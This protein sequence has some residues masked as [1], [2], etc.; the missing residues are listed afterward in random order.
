MGVVF[1]DY[2]QISPPHYPCAGD[3]PGVSEEL[4]P[5][6]YW[7]NAQPDAAAIVDLTI[8]GDPLK[9]KGVGYHDKNWGAEPVEKTVKSWYWGH[10]RL[11]P[12]SLVWFDTV[13]LDGKEHFSSWVTKEDK[14]VSQNCTPGSIVV[15]PW[16]ANSEFPPPTGADAPSGY[17]VRYDMGMEGVLLAKFTQ[18]A[19]VQNADFYKRMIGSIS[20]GIVGGEQYKGRALCEQFQF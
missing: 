13:T 15:R 7:A 19:V 18:E 8:N 5:N 11:G 20:G 12:Y 1:I 17:T 16:G 9:F 10:G 6:I 3:G 14:I 2:D 4:I